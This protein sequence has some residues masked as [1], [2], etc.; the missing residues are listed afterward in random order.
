MEI[1]LKF[2]VQ[3][4]GT[5]FHITLC[6]FTILKFLTEIIKNR[7]S[8]SCKLHSTSDDVFHFNY[9]FPLNSFEI[10]DNST[11]TFQ[12]KYTYFLEE[13]Q[14]KKNKGAIVLCFRC[15]LQIFNCQQQAV[16]KEQRVYIT[17]QTHALHD[18]YT[19]VMYNTLYML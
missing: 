8:S 9:F 17:L 4:C 15:Q 18:I 12:I 6:H 2:L 13:L 14:I 1:F 16:P 19:Y 11:Q 7:N 10:L 3:K 5:I